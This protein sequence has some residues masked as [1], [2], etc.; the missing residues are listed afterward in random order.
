MYRPSWI[1][2]YIK[3]GWFFILGP[4]PIAHIKHVF[5]TTCTCCPNWGWTSTPS[6]RTTRPSS[7]STAKKLWRLMLKRPMGWLIITN[8]IIPFH[9]LDISGYSFHI[10]CDLPPPDNKHN[11]WSSV[12]WRTVRNCQE[13]N[14]K[15]QTPRFSTLW[16]A[17]T[18]ANLSEVAAS[19]GP[20]TLFAPTN[21][22][23]AKVAMAST[24]WRKW[25]STIVNHY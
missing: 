18:A 11:G 5:L 24:W 17:L 3:I 13:K 6:C 12:H 16:A 19:E 15:I 9:K 10:R 4:H 25:F 20:F 23:F 8:V 22:A 21:D 1:C 2:C 7:R 14:L